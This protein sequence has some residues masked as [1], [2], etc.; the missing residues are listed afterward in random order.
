MKKHRQIPFTY[1]RQKIEISGERLTEGP[2]YTRLWRLT[3]SGIYNELWE[4]FGRATRLEIFNF[5]KTLR[6]TDVN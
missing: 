5:I 1:L 4:G 3:S 6:S 2:M